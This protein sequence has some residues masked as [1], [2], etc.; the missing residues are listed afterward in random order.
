MQFDSFHAFISDV[1]NVSSAYNFVV[2]WAYFVKITRSRMTVFVHQNVV[3]SAT[4]D[5]DTHTH[6]HTHTHTTLVA[7]YYAN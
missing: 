6:T 1:E 2:N 5:I 7:R 4:P 3:S